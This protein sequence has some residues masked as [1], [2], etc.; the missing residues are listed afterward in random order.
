MDFLSLPKHLQINILKCVDWKSIINVKFFEKPK[1][2]AINIDCGKQKNITERI[3]IAYLICNEEHQDDEFHVDEAKKIFFTNIEGYEDFLRSND[4]TIL[5][6]IF[7]DI[8]SGTEIIKLFNKYYKGGNYIKEVDLYDY[9]RIKNSICNDILEFINKI[10]NAEYISLVLNF[11]NDHL[12]KDYIFPKM[13][14]LSRLYIEERN[15]TN[16]VT[17]EMILQLINNSS[18][19][20]SLAISF[21]NENIYLDVVKCFTEKVVFCMKNEC[22]G[23]SFNP[24]VIF[25]KSRPLTLLDIEL[26]KDFFIRYDFAITHT[27]FS[28]VEHEFIGRKECELC[29]IY[30]SI[31]FDFDTFFD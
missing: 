19:D 24:R 18:V 22:T 3:K 13:N 14:F 10:R 1:L 25:Y 6:H 12:P 5:K 15:G 4:L 28:S 11:P 7:I 20:F 9:G 26:I 29:G 23:Q 27:A 16:F 2:C 17:K 21:K 30:H 8:C 31:R